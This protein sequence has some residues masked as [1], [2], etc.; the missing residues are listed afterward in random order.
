[1]RYLPEQPE[2][3]RSSLG[4]SWK[5]RPCKKQAKALID[6]CKTRWAERQNAYRHFYQCFKFVVTALEVIALSLHQDDLSDDFAT[7]N[8][9]IIARTKPIHSCR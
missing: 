4:Y 5:E 2:E 1:M 6:L 3:K 8:G 9:I 7:A